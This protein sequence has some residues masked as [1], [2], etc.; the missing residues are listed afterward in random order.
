MNPHRVDA[1]VDLAYGVLIFVSI[2][3]IVSVGTLV[4]LAFGLGV[5]ISYAIHVVWKMARF[6]PEW[7][8]S[9]VEETVGEQV[10]RSIERTV[11]EQVE[12]TI[13]E[14]LGEQVDTVQD[15]IDTVDQRLDRR[16][17][18]D[19]IERLLEETVTDDTEE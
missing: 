8:T 6:D 1:I 4:G 12:E 11:D 16:P 14:T 9:A 7:M 3:L 17:R 5:L 19:E 15:Q 2:V 18:E 10:E 13:E